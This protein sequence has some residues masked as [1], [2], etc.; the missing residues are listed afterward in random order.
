MLLVLT[1]TKIGQVVEQLACEYL[2][3]QGL[4]LIEKNYDCFLGEIDLIMHD[5]ETL[6]FVEVRYRRGCGFGAPIETVTSSKQKKIIKTAYHYLS[7]YRHS[8]SPCRFDV[9]AV[10]GVLQN[11]QIEWVRDAF[12][13]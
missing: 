2:Q 12:G 11:P 3:A 1:T 6:V 7:K 4:S 9:V 10:H 8:D 13:E 5:K